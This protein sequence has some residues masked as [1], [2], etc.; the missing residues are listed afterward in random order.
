MLSDARE[1]F[2]REPRDRSLQFPDMVSRASILEQVI[3]PDAADMPEVLAR[4]ILKLD[5]P[6]A[7]HERYADLAAKAQEG[8]L[9]TEERGELEEYLTV[10]TFLTTI[11]SKARLSL[12]RQQPAA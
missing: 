8:L 3:A 6:E 4:Y 1:S 9:T 10:E 5:F 11:Q 2:C 12:K 7:V